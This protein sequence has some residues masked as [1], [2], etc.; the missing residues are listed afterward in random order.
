MMKILLVNK[1]FF[2]KGGSETY[3]FTLAELLRRRGHQVLFFSMQ[4]ERN[5]PCG[6]EE[7]FVS[8]VDYNGSQT[9]LRKIKNGIKLI[10]SFEAREKIRRLIEREKPDLAIFNLVH[11]QI[12]LSVADELSRS[13][14]PIFFV[15][16]DMIC[17]CPNCTMLSGGA[18][19]EKC[20][21]GRYGH[22]VRGK[23][24]K[25][26][27]FKSALAMLEAYFYKWRKTYDKI[28][29]YLAP[30]RFLADKLQAAGFTSSPVVFLRNPLPADTE[31]GLNAAHENYLLYFGR[32]SAE[33][34]LFTLL[35]AV[36]QMEGVPLL[37]AGEGPLRGELERFARENGLT[38][39]VSFLGYRKGRALWEVVEKSRCVIVPSECY[40]N[41]PYTVMEAMA[42]GKPCIVSDMGGLPELV[43]NGAT[44]YTFRA[45]RAEDLRAA[46]EKLCSLKEPEYAAMCENALKKAKKEFGPE[47]YTDRLLGEY[48]KIK[49]RHGGKWDE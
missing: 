29:L 46:V 27:F 3:F 6:Q 44:G 18:V 28:D 42:K 15:M 31:Y 32:L 25:N 33:K 38:G 20:L 2:Q 1:F 11:R 13:R 34:G 24:V 14:I 35:K 17:V 45:G 19:C 8:H 40:E 21:D 12:T 36:G 4:D 47:R 48:A 16:H 9:G 26:S 5:E 30:S 49:S 39:R 7:F 41:C 37:I 43:E 22:C 10:Y 23:C